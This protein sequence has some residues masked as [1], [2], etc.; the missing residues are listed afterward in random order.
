M[1]DVFARGG[2]ST[3]VALHGTASRPM[4]QQLGAGLQADAA[5]GDAARGARLGGADRNV[6]IDV[7]L[8][9]GV[10]REARDRRLGRMVD[11]NDE[12]TTAATGSSRNGS[13]ANVVKWMQK[14]EADS[15]S[16]GLLAGV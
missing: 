15:G 5:S 3:P 11:M 12:K 7:L 13:Q 6:R 10:K 16:K 14:I 8:D 1:S 4:Q 2:N 9:L